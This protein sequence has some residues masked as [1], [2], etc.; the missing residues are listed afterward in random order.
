VISYRQVLLAEGYEAALAQ[1]V[2]WG[3]MALFLMIYG[4]GRYSVDSLL[5]R[6]RV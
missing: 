1:H 5:D 2:L 3:S 4:P 6:S